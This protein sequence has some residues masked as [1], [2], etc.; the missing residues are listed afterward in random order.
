MRMSRTNC[1]G[2]QYSC[3]CSVDQWFSEEQWC[4]LRNW[5]SSR[6]SR[7][8]Q[9]P[10]GLFLWA[11]PTLLSWGWGW[12]TDRW[13]EHRWSTG[14][15]REP[16]SVCNIQTYTQGWTKGSLIQ[17][18]PLY[19]EFQGTEGPA[20]WPWPCGWESRLWVSGCGQ[21]RLERCC[22]RKEWHC[23]GSPLQSV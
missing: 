12:R 17:K 2:N 4:T 16:L 1:L 23:P 11:S 21:A 9:W 13:S 22:G 7:K 3:A 20:D 14:W 15:C 19:M 8:D 18:L 5:T 6:C 10:W